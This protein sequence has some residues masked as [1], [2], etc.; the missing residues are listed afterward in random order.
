M[1]VTPW[2]YHKQP[3]LRVLLRAAVVLVYAT[4]IQV[5]SVRKPQRTVLLWRCEVACFI[6]VHVKQDVTAVFFLNMNF[7]C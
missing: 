1:I 3:V 4:P 6:R 7:E 5:H 2:Y